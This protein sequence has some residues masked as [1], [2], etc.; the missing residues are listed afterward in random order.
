MNYSYNGKTIVHGSDTQMT[1]DNAYEYCRQVAKHHAKTFYL[2]TLFLPV[3]QRNPIFAMYALLRT[4][5]DVVDTAEDK[6][7]N[8]TLSRTELAGM[9]NSW[10]ERLKECYKGHHHNDPIM[11]AWND[12]L[13]NYHIP[14]ELPLDLMDGVSMDIE[15][16]PFETFDDLYVY[17]YKVASVVGLMCSEI[18]GYNDRKALDHA[19]EL[20]IAMQLTNILRD[21]GEDVDRGRIYLP[22]EDLERFGYTREEFMNKTMNENFI[23]LIRYQIE[24]ARNYY[25]SSGKG[26]PMLE[27][28]SRFAVLVSSVNYSNILK[29]IEENG[30]DVFSRRAYRS[31]YQKI[32]TIPYIWYKS[33]FSA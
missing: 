29:S 1:L 15:F 6:L 33:R 4:V 21:I 8:G 9:M 18:F 12:T 20:G 14:I 32:R 11:M 25:T 31:F 5:D 24:R 22:L 27:K 19:I 26:I 13:R 17:C 3:R 30:Y 2:A 16:K 7:T 10:K 23:E 28:N